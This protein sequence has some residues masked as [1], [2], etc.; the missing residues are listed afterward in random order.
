[1]PKLK[2]CNFISQVGSEPSYMPGDHCLEIFP[3]GYFQGPIVY[4]RFM[5]YYQDGYV[6]IPNSLIAKTMKDIAS[7]IACQG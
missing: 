7:E 2:M 4:L 6:A 1:M 5:Q 3:H